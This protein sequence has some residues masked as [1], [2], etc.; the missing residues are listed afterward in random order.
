M[1]MIRRHPLICYYTLANVLTWW[2]YPLMRFSPLI[3][4][5]GLFGPS[6]A[7]IVLA[8]LTDGRAGVT[9]LLGRTARWRVGLPWY[10]V[11]LG[12]PFVLS[13]V[14]A[15]LSVVVGIGSWQV[16]ELTVLDLMLFVLVVGEELGWRGYALPKLLE[17][18]SALAASAVLGV[19]WGLWHLPTFFGAA[20]PQQG[21]PIVAFVILTIEYSVIMTWI[22]LH[23]DGS[24]L[25]ATLCHGAINLSQGVLLGGLTGSAR[26]WLLAVVYGIAAIAI[27]C[28]LRSRPGADTV[29]AVETAGLS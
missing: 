22:Y 4:L 3:G 8:A 23:T 9:T 2:V 28:L 1:S 24:V 17:T 19:L 20:T 27:G 7:A 18:R 12:L 16:G 21:M 26:Y 15:G 5:A 11:A 6:L 10:V 25:I 29:A 13:L 14:T